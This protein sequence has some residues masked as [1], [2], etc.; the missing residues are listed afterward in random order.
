MDIVC[1]VIEDGTN[2]LGGILVDLEVLFIKGLLPFIICLVVKF[3]C[4]LP[5]RQSCVSLPASE[6]RFSARLVRCSGLSTD[7]Q[8]C[9]LLLL[10]RVMKSI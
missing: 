5:C 3:L 8:G 10:C 6:V 4:P 2:A 1:W 9:D 7:V